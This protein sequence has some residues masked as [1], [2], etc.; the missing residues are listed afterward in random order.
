MRL[1]TRVM[2]FFWHLYD[3]TKFWP[4]HWIGD[5]IE[6]HFHHD[7]NPEFVARCVE[8][9]EAWKQAQ[10]TGDFSAY[11]TYTIEDIEALMEDKNAVIQP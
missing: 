3:R 11:E 6:D 7:Y 8:Q 4:F 10:A 5:W 2:K 1:A 9:M